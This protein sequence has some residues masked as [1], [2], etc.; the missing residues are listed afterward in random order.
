MLQFKKMS[1]TNWSMFKAQ[2][3]LLRGFPYATCSAVSKH[4]CS[5]WHN[6][7]SYVLRGTRGPSNL[8]WWKKGP[9]QGQLV[10][11]CHG[12]IIWRGLENTEAWAS[13]VAQWLRIRLPMQGTQVWSLA[14]EDPTCLRATKPMRHNYWA[15]ALEPVSHS[16]WARVPRA[17][18]PQQEKPLQ[19]EA[20]APQW[21]VTPA[22]HS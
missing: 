12:G 13:L 2:V 15:C 9:F 3:C 18:A 17:R 19:W 21:R 4:Q 22:R 1:C 11:N 6:R 5:Y 20:R 8:E 16:Y 14:R 7:N 10:L